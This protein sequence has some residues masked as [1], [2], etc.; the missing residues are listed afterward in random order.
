MTDTAPH[1]RRLV[2]V[3]G[4]SG[5]GRTSAIRVL[6]DL[7]Y[8]AI[9][10]MPLRLIRALLDTPG[11]DKSLALGI[12][13]RNR[14]FSIT[15]IM[16]AL[17]QIAAVPGLI[18]ELL[19]LDCA[20]EVLLNRFSETRRRHP[21]AAEDRVEAGIQRELE[22]LT[23]LRA[24]ADVLIDT[25]HLNV[26]QLRAEVEHWFSPGDQSPLAVSLQSFSYKR[27]L[28]RSV[29][30]VFDCRFLKN[31]F[32]EKGLRAAT[33]QDPAVRDYI[34]SDPRAAEFEG[35]LRDLLL[36]QLPAFLEEGKS[37]LSVAFGCT[38]GQ[39]RSVA[40]AETMA[41]ALAAAGWQVSIRHRELDRRKREEA[42]P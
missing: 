19:Y 6:E 28:P 25:S 1:P 2:L 42:A 23:P 31:P 22:L 26:H 29:D 21:L 41:A 34:W 9:D 27:G 7:G 39:H 12:D 36:W 33:G 35:K 18:P 8:E 15:A 14:D 20:T 32:W 38:G 5:A 4:P 17:G 30:M 40:F 16:D 10:N 13:P 24:R 37:H 3:T 11:P